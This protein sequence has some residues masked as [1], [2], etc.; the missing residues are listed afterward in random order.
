MQSRMFRDGQDD[1]NSVCCGTPLLILWN[2]SSLL[3]VSY[4][5]LSAEILEFTFSYQYFGSW[6]SP[7]GVG[8]WYDTLYISII[9]NFHF[10]G[11]MDASVNVDRRCRSCRV[12]F[13]QVIHVPPWERCPRSV[14]LTKLQC[15]LILHRCIFHVSICSIYFMPQIIPCLTFFS[16]FIVLSQ[17]FTMTFEDFSVEG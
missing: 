2:F 16:F 6:R 7:E 1:E 15:E 8:A 9:M 3:V 11:H 10:V 13:L 5:N 12:F 14:G 17:I 4:R